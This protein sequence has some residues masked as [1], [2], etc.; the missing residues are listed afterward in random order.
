MPQLRPKNREKAP[1]FFI[2]RSDSFR[3]NPKKSQK[4]SN[5]ARRSVMQMQQMEEKIA[6]G[7]ARSMPETVVECLKSKE[8]P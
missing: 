2:H 8:Q 6:D 1:E 4:I 3:S 5:G 7:A